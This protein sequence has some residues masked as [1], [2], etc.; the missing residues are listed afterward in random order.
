MQ[1][2]P[3]IRAFL[4]YVSSFKAAFWLV[5][6]T[7]AAADIILAII[8]WL[9]GQLTTALTQHN[10]HVFGWTAALIAT[11]IGHDILWRTSEFLYLRLLL[12]RSHRFDDVV[13]GAILQ[14][15]YEY[16]VDKFTGKI[17][18]YA[19]MLGREFRELL[20]N[21]FEEYINLLIAMP[22]IAVTMFT[23][24][25]Y[26]GVIFVTSLTLMFI[27]GRK[28]ARIAANAERIQADEHSTLD[29][30]VVDVI[31]NFVSVKAFGSEQREAERLHEKRQSL[32]SAA[33]KSYFKNILF[34]AVMSLFIRWI[35]WP[36][37]F[38]LNV[39]LYTQGHIGLPQL[40]TF[41]TAIVLFSNF[42]WE[43]V[44][45]ISQLNIKVA[46][47]EEAYH[48]LFNERNIFTSHLP[49]A[50]ALLPTS[51]THSLEFQNLSFAYPDKPDSLV[52]RDINLTI[53]HGEKI[54]IV[55]PSGGGKSTLLK[56]LLGYYPI[57]HGALLLDNT[58]IDNR[59]LTSLV[60]YV[61]QDTAVFHRSIRENI[62]YARPEA[63]ESEIYMAAK[64]AQADDFIHSLQ[65]GYDTLV[66][67]RGVKL[68]GGQRQRI[69]IARALLKNAP[70]LLLDEATSALDS[71]SE[72]LI[73]K[74]LLGLLE[75]R[76]A[77][78]IAHRLS[79]IQ[80]MD[81]IVVFDK[82]IIAEEGTH[83]QLLNRS[84]GLYARLWG[85]QS[86]GFIEE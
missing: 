18:S 44:W 11:S 21:F 67:E 71:E 52:L 34:W 10:G 24:N 66:G 83:T 40:A 86:G 4:R 23:V 62:A 38:I 6:T 76:T 39:Y 51:F 65:A 77:L 72:K 1:S 12:V 50:Q 78:V 16:F 42:I 14:H 61:P 31:A 41:L 2:Y 74:A 81:R 25:V 32:I 54:G 8:P 75:D 84:H 29:G 63:S 36:S 35:V 7:F 20:D 82:G 69:A 22:I 19:N 27:T 85:H 79:T 43:V 60:A 53:R 3:S 57:E 80:H 73:Q 55:G 13:F 70:L 30:L 45:H 26:T 59:S 9:I 5:A 48:Y 47:I 17:S 37:T 56:L 64:Y 58:S 15:S 46:G 28:L 33:E 49:R 68:S